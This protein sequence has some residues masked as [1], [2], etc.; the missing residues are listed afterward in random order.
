[1]IAISGQEIS[2]SYGH[3]QVLHEVSIQIN[4]GECF[5]LF[6]PNGAGKTTL[7]KIFATLSRPTAG[8]IKILGRDA[9]KEKDMVR[10]S[11]MFLAHGSYLYD[12]LNAIENLQF[13]MGLRH[14]T[15]SLRSIASTL[16]R[17]G[18]GAFS[19]MK[20]RNFSA[21]MKKRLNLAKAMLAQPHVL[22][23]DEPFTALDDSGIALMQ[24]YIV[25]RVTN[26]GAVLMST[27]DRDKAA[28]LAHHAGVLS[29][30][31]LKTVSSKAG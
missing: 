25:E 4:Q 23:L 22:L 6:G 5:A 26:G 15:P 21:G 16:D 10:A 20:V 13:A 12:E 27:H 18:I 17:V 24:E 29:Q 8:Q 14:L 9:V 19:G 3:Y 1:M 2:K 31:I 30:G 11:M 7:L 28:P